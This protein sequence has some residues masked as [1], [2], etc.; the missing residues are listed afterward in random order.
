MNNNN[1]APLN[2]RSLLESRPSVTSPHSPDDV[3]R[4]IKF[5]AP[6]VAPVVPRLAGK[7][8]PAPAAAAT[9]ASDSAPRLPLP[10]A[11]YPVSNASN[12]VNEAPSQVL[13]RVEENFKS[14]GVHV[15]RVPEES[16]KLMCQL[17]TELSSTKFTVAMWD[18]SQ[19]PQAPAP[20]LVEVDR[21]NGCPFLFHSLL[22][23]AFSQKPEVK[24]F[25]C[26][27]MP[28]GGTKAGGVHTGCVEN[29]LT[30]L[31][32][33]GGDVGQR[34]AAV[35]ALAILCA[36]DAEVKNQLMAAR[37]PERLASLLQ[38]KDEEIRASAARLFKAMQ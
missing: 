2:P 7:T 36:K 25:Q 20:L 15:E 11:G 24:T 37:A 5:E 16:N 33:S 12:F 13:A 4:S 26:L 22:S 21:V 3:Y 8:S 29:V 1:N 34:Q 17:N 35:R 18:V 19:E 30:L 6:I 10:L 27:E 14:H 28:A 23:Q 32:A 38:D 31:S 9:P